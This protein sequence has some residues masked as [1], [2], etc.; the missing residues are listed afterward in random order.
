MKKEKIKLPTAYEP[1]SLPPLQSLTKD[2]SLSSIQY[3]YSKPGLLLKSTG[4]HKKSGSLPKIKHP[5]MRN[6]D[7][8]TETKKK[9][10]VKSHSVLPLDYDSRQDASQRPK[11]LYTISDSPVF[12]RSSA[13][14]QDLSS[15]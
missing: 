1:Y 11:R 7:S 13:S 6:D 5:I 15:R 3:D 12:F 9:G 4:R 10:H 2:A 14:Q 8:L